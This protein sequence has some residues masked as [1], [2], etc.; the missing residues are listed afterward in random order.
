MKTISIAAVLLLLGAGCVTTETSVVSTELIEESATSS[1]ASETSTSSKEGS[2][3]DV[4]TNTLLADGEIGF[5]I[6]PPEEWGTFSVVLYKRTFPGNPEIGEDWEYHGSFSGRT[7]V[8]YRAT[9][10]E[11]VIGRGGYPGDVLG[12]EKREDGYYIRI[13]NNALDLQVPESLIV[14]EVP[15]VNGTALLLQGP[16]VAEGPSPFPNATGDFV[17]Y[18]NTPNGPLAGG[19]F[20]TNLDEGAV[21]SVDEMKALLATVTIK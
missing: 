10:P 21:I 19:V 12:Y 1:T 2:I 8:I 4:K 7:D 20:M 5:T 17:A 18:L 16:P 6:S 9:D 3:G 14:G 11:H 15:L 13:G